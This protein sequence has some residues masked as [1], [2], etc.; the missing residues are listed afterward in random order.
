LDANSL[1]AVLGL[2]IAIWRRW[3]VLENISGY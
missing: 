2:R 1:L 3:R